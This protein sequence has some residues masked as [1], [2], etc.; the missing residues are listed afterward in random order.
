[1]Q[2]FISSTKINHHDNLYESLTKARAML[3]VF[4][5]TADLHELGDQTIHDYLWA[6]DEQVN[7]ALDNY[8][9]A[10]SRC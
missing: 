5:H 8:H 3:A 9:R 2:T 1:M 7:I 6:L 4:L 10:L